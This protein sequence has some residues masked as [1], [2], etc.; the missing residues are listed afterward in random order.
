MLQANIQKYSGCLAR[1]TEA[2]DTISAWKREVSDLGPR[3]ARALSVVKEYVDSVE[4][5]RLDY[6]AVIRDLLYMLNFYPV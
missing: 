6:I 5:Q 2:F 1:V 4:Q 3:H